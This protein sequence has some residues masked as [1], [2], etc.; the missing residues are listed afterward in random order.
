M[1]VHENVLFDNNANEM[2]FEDFKFS[3]RLDV[4][5]FVYDRKYSDTMMAESQVIAAKLTF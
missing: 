1:K 2:G 4:V 3:N 5:G